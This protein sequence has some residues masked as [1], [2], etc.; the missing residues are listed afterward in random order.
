MERL[1]QRVVAEGL[2]VRNVEE[3][4][5]LGMEPEPAKRASSGRDAGHDPQM[6]DLA[7]RV[8][9]R[10][11]TRVKINLGKRKGRMTIEFASVEDLHRVL[12]EMG[13]DPDGA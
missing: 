3:I 7:G 2:S 8:S 13:V 1:A 9:D 10:L 12:G 4:V 5:A 11:D 6:E